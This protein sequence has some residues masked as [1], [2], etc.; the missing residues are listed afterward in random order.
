M[1]KVTIYNVTLDN[2]K[3]LVFE[4]RIPNHV[5]PHVV[6]ATYRTRNVRVIE[7]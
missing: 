6:K 7:D 5:L 4:N 3:E 1:R 2:G